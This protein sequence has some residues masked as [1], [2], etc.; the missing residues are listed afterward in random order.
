MK[1]ESGNGLYFRLHLAPSFVIS[2]MIPARS[3]EPELHR[4]GR[5]SWLC[6]LPAFRTSR[7]ISASLTDGEAAI[8]RAC[9]VILSCLP[10]RSAHS[11]IV[12]TFTASSLFITA[13]IESNSSALSAAARR[14][15]ASTALIRGG[16]GVADH[17]E[18]GSDACAVFRSSA[19]ADSFLASLSRPASPSPPTY[20][21]A[22]A[23]LQPQ[24]KVPQALNEF[25]A[26]VSPSKV[27]LSCLRYG[28]EAAETN[29]RRPVPHQD[30]VAN[31]IE[32]AER[33]RH[34]L[35]L[36]QQEARVHPEAR[37]RLAGRDSACAISFS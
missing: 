14:R 35:A 2:T 36:N 16:I 23:Q 17:V 13:K 10:S 30:Q 32:V 29:R 11:R 12:F 8:A 3:T 4:H 15:P 9:G 24:R 33:L 20:L 18:D 26:C 31:G 25:A 27:K 5:N 28:T 37:E 21:P 34:L 19:S 6:A 7:S 22:V 1:L